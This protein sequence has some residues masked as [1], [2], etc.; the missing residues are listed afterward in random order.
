MKDPRNR[1]R[2][3]EWHIMGSSALTGKGLFEGVSGH[4]T[5]LDYAAV[6]RLTFLNPSAVAGL[7]GD[8]AIC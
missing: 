8:Q 7:A 2:S 3:G 1:G 4:K 5:R 6:G